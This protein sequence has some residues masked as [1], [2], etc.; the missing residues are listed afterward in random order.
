MVKGN[1]AV[2]QL[3]DRL[4][5]NLKTA[6]SQQL[7]M[8]FKS[9]FRQEEDGEEEVKN[10]YLLLPWNDISLIIDSINEDDEQMKIYFGCKGLKSILMV[11][12]P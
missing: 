3:T 2:P 7:S 6:D 8:N 9:T 4:N 1:A 10:C 5:T 11:S 12:P